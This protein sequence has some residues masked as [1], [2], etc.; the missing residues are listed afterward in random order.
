M[1]RN[2]YR[3]SLPELDFAEGFVW[4]IIDD[5]KPTH[6]W[7]FPAEKVISEQQ[8]KDFKLNYLIDFDT[9][10]VFTVEGHSHNNI[11]L[12]GYGHRTNTW[13]INYVFGTDDSNMI[14]YK[15]VGDPFTYK[16]DIGN[17]LQVWHEENVKKIDECFTT[18]GDIL[19]A[20]T[21]IP[22]NVVNKS[23]KMRWCFS[24]RGSRY[25]NWDTIVDRLSGVSI[26]ENARVS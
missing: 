9:C 10:L 15:P 20:K 7:N 24:F 8:R 25:L 11:H 6:S 21:N 14:W 22:H 18:D 23:D 19:L 26:T 4:P 5:S 2:Y 12:D 3:L 1:V 16:P 13:A 17:I